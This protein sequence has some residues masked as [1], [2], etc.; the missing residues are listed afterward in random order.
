MYVSEQDR[1]I[2]R[3]VEDM[4]VNDELQE[5]LKYDPSLMIKQSC[6]VIKKGIFKKETVKFFEVFHEIPARYQIIYQLSGSGTKDIV[7]AYLHG[8]INGCVNR[9]ITPI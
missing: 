6:R 4:E 2:M 3:K 9:G 8:I 1:T 5:A 7:I